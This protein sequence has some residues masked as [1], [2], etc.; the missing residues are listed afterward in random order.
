MKGSERGAYE[1]GVKSSQSP[2]SQNIQLRSNYFDSQPTSCSKTVTVLPK[3]SA[4]IAITTQKTSLFLYEAGKEW[5][6]ENEK[7]K[8][9]KQLHKRWSTREPMYACMCVCR[10]AQKQKLAIMLET[11]YTQQRAAQ[12]F[13]SF[14]VFFFFCFLFSLLQRFCNNFAL[15]ISHCNCSWKLHRKKKTTTTKKN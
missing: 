15:F 3:P 2:A 9:L 14:S 7:Q 5:K 11:T 8:W 6:Y 12:R 4:T 13:F 1:A 10:S